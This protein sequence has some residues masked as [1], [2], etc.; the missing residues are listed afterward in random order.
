[1]REKI[2][3]AVIGPSKGTKAELAVRKWLRE[4]NLDVVE[5]DATLP[6][7]PDA[8]IPSLQLA[9][10]VDG[11]FWH[12]PEF[13]A[14]RKINTD[15][16]FW[17]DK[18]TAN[19]ER[20]R[21]A[22][23]EL[24]K[25]GWRVVRVWSEDVLGKSTQAE[26]KRK[27]L[28]ATRINF[29]DNFELVYL[30]HRS[31]RRAKGKL[32]DAKLKKYG[33]QVRAI[34]RAAYNKYRYAMGVLG[35][36]ECDLYNVG[37]VYLMIFVDKW[38]VGGDEKKNRRTLW[39]FLNQRFGEWAMIAAKKNYNIRGNMDTSPLTEEEYMQ[40]VRAEEPPAAD[41]DPGRE[42][43]TR[44]LRETFARLTARE[45]NHRVV[46][47]AS[48][49]HGDPVAR[50]AARAWCAKNGVDWEM[51]T[52]MRL[53]ERPNMYAHYVVVRYDPAWRARAEAMGIDTAGWP[54]D[55][56][57]HKKTSGCLALACAPEKEREEP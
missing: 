26:A 29:H 42:E 32:T 21:Q 3:M 17:V 9:V 45:R 47:V 44:R 4:E 7:K 49:R 8:A 51:L 52:W 56:R 16:Q 2:N 33:P 11:R 31:V 41:P 48:L 37:L 15:K 46:E 53:R 23:A 34:S 1:M 43:N 40:C 14:G 57:R 12:D 10:F 27:V 39:Q 54:A 28:S 13:V 5:N 38:E 55:H 22:N 50:E 6:G 18:A 36:D 20:D 30:R 24:A 19:A 35:A 25:A